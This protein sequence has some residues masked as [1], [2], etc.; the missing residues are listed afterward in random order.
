VGPSKTY[1]ENGKLKE[2]VTYDN[3]KPE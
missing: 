2:E 3:D 1:S